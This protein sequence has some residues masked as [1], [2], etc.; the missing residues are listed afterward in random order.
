[1]TCFPAYSTLS[2]MERPDVT[3]RLLSATLLSGVRVDPSASMVN[4]SGN[5]DS[6]RSDGM[7]IKIFCFAPLKDASSFWLQVT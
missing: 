3:G 6:G 2:E 7:V 4:F 1:M 5:M